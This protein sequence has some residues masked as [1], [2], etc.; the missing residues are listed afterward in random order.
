MA[1]D[2][3]INR[4]AVRRPRALILILLGFFLC[5]YVAGNYARIIINQDYLERRWRD[6]NPALNSPKRVLPGDAVVKLVIPKIGLEAMVVEGTTEQSLLLG[7]G[8][9]VNSVLPGATGNSAIA[10]HRD[11]FFRNLNRLVPGDF[12]YADDGRRRYGYV[13]TGSRIVAPSDTSV[14]N[15]SQDARLTLITC[16]PMRYVGPAPKRFVVSARLQHE[17]RDVEAASPGR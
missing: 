2:I 17:S 6:G 8:H 7:P 15:P 10:A 16:Y 9:L 3:H 11:T 12:I 1:L 5:S 13:V 4:A 14:L